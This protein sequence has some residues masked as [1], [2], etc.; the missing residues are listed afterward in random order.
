M[1][2]FKILIPVETVVHVFDQE[3]ENRK[4]LW[5]KNI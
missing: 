2:M 5:D 4:K 3:T 1:P